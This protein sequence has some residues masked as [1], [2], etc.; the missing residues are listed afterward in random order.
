MRRVPR[1]LLDEAVASRN[2]W[3]T[4]AADWHNQYRQAQAEADRLTVAVAELAW[5]N[6][7]LA[8]RCE[9]LEMTSEDHG[10]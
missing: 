6:V 1:R 9:L 10:G 5:K 4:R 2:W 7:Q 8:S 3:Q